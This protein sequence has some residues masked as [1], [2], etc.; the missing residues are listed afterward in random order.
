MNLQT[1]E[2]RIELLKNK[3]PISQIEQEYLKL[4][5]IKVITFTNK[6]KY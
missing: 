4:N 6:I 1:R 5:N 2:E 3:T